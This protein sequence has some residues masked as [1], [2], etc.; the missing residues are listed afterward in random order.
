M[1]AEQQIRRRYYDRFIFPLGNNSL[2]TDNMPLKITKFSQVSASPAQKKARP[3]MGRDKKA[4][5]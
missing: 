3:N 4:D 2:A 5:R 1:I